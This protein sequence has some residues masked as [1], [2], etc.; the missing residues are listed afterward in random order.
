MLLEMPNFLSQELRSYKITD[1]LIDVFP[2]NAQVEEISL[3]AG[4]L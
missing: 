3:L 1:S 2:V 4:I